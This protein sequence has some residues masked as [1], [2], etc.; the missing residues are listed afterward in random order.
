MR[1]G[2]IAAALLVAAGCE[3]PS[4]R[5]TVPSASGLFYS[6]DL[7][8]Q[9][10]DAQTHRLHVPLTVAVTFNNP[11]TLLIDT[12]VYNRATLAERDDSSPALQV[13]TGLDPAEP[14]G[15]VFAHAGQTYQVVTWS[16]PLGCQA[17]MTDSGAS[18]LDMTLAIDMSA[19]YEF[20]VTPMD[21]DVTVWRLEFIGPDEDGVWLPVRRFHSWD[22][23]VG[24]DETDR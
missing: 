14:V 9:V 20:G 21:V 8:E 10:Y 11:G 18:K 22:F 1:I 17:P 4:K 16:L 15:G 24:P 23:R 5:M 13:S 19:G 3:A 12:Q 6:V 7:T 2:L